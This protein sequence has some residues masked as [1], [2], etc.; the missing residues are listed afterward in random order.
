TDHAGGQVMCG[1]V[2]AHHAGGEDEDASTGEAHFIHLAGLHH[3][4]VEGLGQ[5]QVA[6]VAIRAVGFE[7]VDLR[8]DPAQAAD[9]NRLRFHFARL[10]EQGEQS[11]DFLGAAEGEGGDEHAAFAFED[12]VEGGGEAFDL[13]F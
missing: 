8:E 13:G 5:L 7:V 2:F 9:V 11:E 3:S 6:V 4:E 12:P 10:H 1:R